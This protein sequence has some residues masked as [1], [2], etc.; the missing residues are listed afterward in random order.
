M[1]TTKMDRVGKNQ[2]VGNRNKRKERGATMVEYAVM[3]ALIAV[4]VIVAVKAL[5]SNI[6]GQFVAVGTQIN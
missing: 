5:G 1:E 6:S 2:N 3:V 4:A